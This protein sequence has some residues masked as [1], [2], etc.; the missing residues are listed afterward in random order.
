MEK[1]VVKL[2]TC[3]VLDADLGSMNLIHSLTRTNR[4]IQSV[5]SSSC[6]RTV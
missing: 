1:E 3:A 6:S 2:E 5:S 4:V